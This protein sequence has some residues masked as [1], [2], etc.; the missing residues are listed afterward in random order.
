MEQTST[1]TIVVLGASGDLTQRKL[2]PALFSQFRKGRL[3]AGVRIMGFARRPW[4]DAGF[5][6]HLHE[7][8]LAHAPSATMRAIA[9]LCPHPLLRA[10]RP[11]QRT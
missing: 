5:R 7:G 10:R 3:P 8:M 2:I 6:A 9:P 1:T 4:D 11:G